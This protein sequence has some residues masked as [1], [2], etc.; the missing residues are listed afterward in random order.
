MDMSLGKLWEM[1]KDSGSQE[2]DTTERLDNSKSCCHAALQERGPPG[3]CPE[4][5]DAP[6]IKYTLSATMPSET[7]AACCSEAHF[8]GCGK[9][10]RSPTCYVS[11]GEVA[12]SPT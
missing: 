10:R 12:P 7:T 11:G 5:R 8:C 2:L 3:G 1:V 9:A 6:T 4:V